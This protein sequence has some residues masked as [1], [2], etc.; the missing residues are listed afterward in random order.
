MIDK[1]KTKN[2]SFNIND[3]YWIV[4]GITVE[5]YSSKRKTFV[6]VAD[7]E[8]TDWLTVNE[9]PTNISNNDL[10]QYFFL[11]GLPPVPVR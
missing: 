4:D 6:N 11:M 5:V 9:K 1:T 2:R 8:Y 10:N 3:W 7:T